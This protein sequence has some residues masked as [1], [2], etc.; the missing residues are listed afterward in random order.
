MKGS[1]RKKGATWSFRLDLGKQENGKRKQIERSGFA[2]EKEAQAM[3]AKY[4][5]EYNNNGEIVENKKITLNEVYQEFIDNEANTT[6]KHSTVTR[7]NSLYR[8]HICNEIGYNYIGNFSAQKLQEYINSKRSENLSDE[9][10]RSKFDFLQ[11][12]LL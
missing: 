9:Y 11:Y 2:T 1:V 3:L 4:I 10:I 7:Y 12:T 5:D 8:N 6:R